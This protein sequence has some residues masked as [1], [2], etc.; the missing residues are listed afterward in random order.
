MAD[1]LKNSS[2]RRPR[3]VINSKYFTDVSDSLGFDFACTG[4]R[5]GNRYDRC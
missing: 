2:D 1:V 3:V 4:S 5:I